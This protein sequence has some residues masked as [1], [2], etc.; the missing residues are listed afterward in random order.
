MKTYLS[1]LCLFCACAAGVSHAAQAVGSRPYEMVWANR[2]KDIYPPLVDFENLNGWK[3][4][5]QNATV[6]FETSREQQL[7]DKYV[8]KLTYRANTNAASEIRLLPPA[9]IPVKVPWDALS[10]WIYGNTIRGQGGTPSVFVSAIFTDAK[11]SEVP[12]AQAKFSSM[13]FASRAEP[14]FPTAFYISIISQHFKTA[15]RHCKFPRAPNAASKCCR[16]KVQASTP[17]REHFRFPTASKP[18]CPT[19]PRKNLPRAF[20]GMGVLCCLNIAVKTGI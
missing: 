8:G 3:T 17:A 16:E 2:D 19:M 1:F 7:W 14:S 9:P 18:F 11:G 12:I 20:A 15:K 6:T 5:T 13:D 4:E 10:C